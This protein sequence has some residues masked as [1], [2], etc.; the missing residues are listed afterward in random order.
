MFKEIRQSYLLRFESSHT[1]FAESLSFAPARRVEA[2]AS[3]KTLSLS[4][5]ILAAASST[6][7]KYPTF[8]VYQ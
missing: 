5:K 2:A 6:R 3:A 1:R 8:E 7:V 4:K